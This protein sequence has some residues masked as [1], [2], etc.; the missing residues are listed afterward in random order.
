VHASQHEVSLRR[1]CTW[2]M[3]TFQDRW[4]DLSRWVRVR[5]DVDVVVPTPVQWKEGA[6]DSSTQN[7]CLASKLISQPS[8]TALPILREVQLLPLEDFS[9]A[10]SHGSTIRR[11]RPKLAGAVRLT[12]QLEERGHRHSCR[13]RSESPCSRQPLQLIFVNG[14]NVIG[15]SLLFAAGR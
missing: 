6:L 15:C 14:A 13:R 11:R 3:L 2:H 12:Q 9:T 7:A 8:S 1:L 10:S 5:H 4:H